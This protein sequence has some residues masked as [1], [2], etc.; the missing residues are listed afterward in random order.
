MLT[1]CSSC[2]VMFVLFL[3]VTDHDLPT[4]RF[5]RAQLF[6]TMFRRTKSAPRELKLT[7]IKNTSFDFSRQILRASALGSNSASLSSSYYSEPHLHS[8]IQYCAIL[9][10]ISPVF[11]KALARVPSTPF[12]GGIS[13]GS[14]PW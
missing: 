7:P 11:Q 13:E 3:P 9:F 4:I 8:P 2:F 6:T 14:Q 12:R 10:S 5:C 1:L